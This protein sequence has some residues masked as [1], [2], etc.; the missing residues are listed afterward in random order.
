MFLIH[1]EC[2]G[3]EYEEGVFEVDMRLIYFSAL[4]MD[5]TG[6]AHVF[7]NSCEYKWA[8]LLEFLPILTNDIVKRGMSWIHTIHV[9][10]RNAHYRLVARCLQLVVY[11]N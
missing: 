1:H 10:T 3:K 4:A 6:T 2:V 5:R 11:A 9:V 7:M 8:D